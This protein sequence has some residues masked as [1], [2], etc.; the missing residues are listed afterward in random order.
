[1]I[2]LTLAQ[3]VD[4]FE[5][6]SAL[7]KLYVPPKTAYRVSKLMKATRE[8]AKEF[9]ERRIAIFRE[10]GEEREPSEEERKGGIG[11]KVL[12]V[13]LGKVR[14]LRDR[15]KELSDIEVEIDAH[16]LAMEDIE[17]FKEVSPEVITKLG[18]CLDD[19]ERKQ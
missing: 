5:G 9:E 13:Q 3:C 17:A 2:K 1:M 10:L 6:L 16:P 4:A 11:D 19:T 7:S 14:E 8:E 12:E 15:L 18:P